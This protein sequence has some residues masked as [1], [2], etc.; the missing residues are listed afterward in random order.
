MTVFLLWG[1]ADLVVTTI[2]EF[3]VVTV[4]TDVGKGSGANVSLTISFGTGV[5]VGTGT[6]TGT[7]VG[8][9][10]GAGVGE[11]LTSGDVMCGCVE[12][13]FGLL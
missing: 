13:T 11:D 12:L 5:G 9:G 1:G 3:G 10:T 8:V 2:V 6:G 7:G 4:T